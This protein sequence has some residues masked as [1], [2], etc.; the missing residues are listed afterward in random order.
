[1]L[2]LW[3]SYMFPVCF[4]CRPNMCHLFSYTVPY[5][6][7]ICFPT[8]FLHF[9]PYLFPAIS[10]RKTGH[11][12]DFC[13]SFP[14]FVSGYIP[15]LSGDC[16]GSVPDFSG[17]MFRISPAFFLETWGRYMAGRQ[18][19]WSNKFR[20][21]YALDTH[22]GMR[23]GYAPVSAGY[24]PGFRNFRPHW[25]RVVLAAGHMYPYHFVLFCRSSVYYKKVKYCFASTLTC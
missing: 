16:R 1:M 20:L 25:H 22:Q 2:F 17:R 9:L 24:V 12:P 5:G 21:G 15:D 19:Y 18:N 6:F 11:V 10:G 8:R 13:G 4:P 7:S 3:A 14:W 23:Q